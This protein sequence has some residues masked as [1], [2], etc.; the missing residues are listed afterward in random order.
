ME[1]VL[2]K[3]YTNAAMRVGRITHETRKYDWERPRGTGSV[4]YVRN[5]R[6]QT[7]DVSE[8][9]TSS[10]PARKKELER[11]F[12]P[13]SLLFSSEARGESDNLPRKK[14]KGSEKQGVPS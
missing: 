3:L 4:V 14:K 12:S 2:D 9:Q 1:K 8:R 5:S 11:I 7:M 13:S 6:H 10:Q